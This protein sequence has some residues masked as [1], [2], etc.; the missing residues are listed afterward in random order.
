MEI[1]AQLN[2]LRIAPRKVRLVLDLIRGL[3]VA[4]ARNQLLFMG[5]RS[6]HPI[7]KLLNS[8]VA[9]AKN[10][11]GIEEGN[12]HIKQIYANKGVV[13]KRWL[14]RAM[15]RATP[16]LKKTSNVILV[17]NAEG[18]VGKKAKKTRVAEEGGKKSLKGNASSEGKTKKGVIGKE[19]I[20]RVQSQS[21]VVKK[22]FRRKSI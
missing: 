5:K 3:S 22:M 14:P 13:L 7:L 11:H 9:N 8:A 2:H 17:L 16:I 21:S 19:D 12:L 18:A 10:N 6:S 1:K 20:K 4:E 15:G